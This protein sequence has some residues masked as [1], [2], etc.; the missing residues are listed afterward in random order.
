MKVSK[1]E[2]ERA[3]KE[4]IAKIVH[5]KLSSFNNLIENVHIVRYK[6]ITTKFKQ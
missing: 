1:R 3:N 6:H 2:E 4:R 5:Q